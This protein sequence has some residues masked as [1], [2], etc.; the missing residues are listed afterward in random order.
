MLDALGAEVACE[1]DDEHADRQMIL[2]RTTAKLAT[3]AAAFHAV[4]EADESGEAEPYCTTCRGWIGIFHGLHGWRHFRGDPAPGGQRELYDPGHQA[5][6]GWC[7]P[8]GRALSP[9]QC[10]VVGQALADAVT[11]QRHY[12]GGCVVCGHDPAGACLDHAAETGQ[13]SAYR[14]LAAVLAR[15]LPEITGED[16]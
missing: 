14:Q 10:R 4:D 5:A 12:L 11:Y 3:V 1:L 2:G 8:P 16:R 7:V 9:A 6:P 13:G 15:A